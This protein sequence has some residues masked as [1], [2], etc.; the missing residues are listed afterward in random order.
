MLSTGW[1]R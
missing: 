1:G